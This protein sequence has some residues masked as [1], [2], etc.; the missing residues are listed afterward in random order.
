M[1][2]TMV[3]SAKRCL[4]LLMAN[5]AGWVLLNPHGF[6]A[7]W[8]GADDAH[9]VTFAWDEPEPSGAK[10]A[11]N[12]F[13]SG[14]IS[15]RVPYLFRTPPG[16]NLLVRGPANWPRDGAAPLEGIVETDW[17]VATFTM[18]WQLTRPGHPV[19]FERGEPFCM[20]VPQRR[21][22]LESFDA[23]VQ[24]LEREP[25][26]HTQTV[27]WAENRHEGQVRR[28]LAEHAKAPTEEWTPAELEYFRGELPDGARAPEHQLKLRLAAFTDPGDAEGDAA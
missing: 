25:E 8:G 16:W 20:V 19:R 26:I 12:N 18:N 22:E 24:P 17:A 10:P 4:P 27:R 2:P 3:R 14:V 5:Q 13:G 1:S 15:W 11:V 21:G 7:T 28:F 23:L 6:E 9:S